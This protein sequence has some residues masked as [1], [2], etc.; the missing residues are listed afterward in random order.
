MKEFRTWRLALTASGCFLGAGYVSG[1]EL[2]RFFGAFGLP[3]FAGRVLALAVQ[4]IFVILLLRLGQKTGISSIDRVLIPG[5]HPLLHRLA[6]GAQLMFL[7]GV[8]VVMAAG[9]GA[10]L[11]QLFPLPGPLGGALFCAAVTVISFRGMDGL[12]RVC[13]VLVPGMIAVTLVI[14]TVVLIKNGVSPVAELK[15]T[16]TNP[17]LPSWP[18]SAL[19]YVSY[20]IFGAIGVLTPI[21]PH[22]PDARTVRR[23]SLLSIL[24]LLV[25]SAGILPALSAAPEAVSA[26]LP[27]LALASG[28]SPVLGYAYAALL[29]CGM[30]GTGVSFSVAILYYLSA[31]YPAL[32]RRRRTTAVSLAA[33]AFCGS[34]LGFGDLIG[35]VYPFF[36]Y[37]GFAAMA[38]ILAHWLRVRK[39]GSA[40][41]TASEES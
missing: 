12:A 1:Q 10:V 23:G 28:L 21:G 6:G 40:A 27:M 38:C 25:I 22:V 36:G 33:L 29:L 41:Q 20:N 24:L 4:L 11:R 26:E 9:S 5:D 2:W 16:N 31:R 30:L 17:M 7:F 37:L 19:T 32:A 34:L 8:Y 18:V 3:G 35:T 39:R 15:P 14:S 13:A